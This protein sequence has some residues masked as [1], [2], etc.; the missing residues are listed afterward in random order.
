MTLRHDLKMGKS[1]KT[2]VFVLRK[3]RSAINPRHKNSVIRPKGSEGERE[4]ER[5]RPSRRWLLAL[6]A[7]TL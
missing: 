1:G 4:I 2:T 5:G 6:A 3:V 7:F